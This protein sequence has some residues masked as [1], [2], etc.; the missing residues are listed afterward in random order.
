MNWLRGPAGSIDRAHEDGSIAKNP[1][2]RI[3]HGRSRKTAGAG[4]FWNDVSLAKHLTLEAT[5]HEIAGDDPTQR[6]DVA[7]RVRRKPI[8]LQLRHLVLGLAVRCGA[9]TSSKTQSRGKAGGYNKQ[10]DRSYGS[11][12]FP[13][14]LFSSLHSH[15]PPNLPPP[16][17]SAPP[18]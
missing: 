11:P 14:A 16:R 10:K 15:P 6:S 9:L 5:A 12:K 4:A 1:Y 18:F 7:C 2:I 3:A 17:P 13:P 8:A